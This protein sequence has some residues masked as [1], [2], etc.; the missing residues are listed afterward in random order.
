MA[1]NDTELLL[2]DDDRAVLRAYRNMLARQ[3]FAVQTASNGQA[4]AALLD[5]R[6]FDVIVS[7]IA[8]PEISGID[9][10]RAVRARDLDVPVILMTGGPDLGTAMAAVEHGAFRY[11][12]KP[13]EADEL[14]ATI[15]EAAKLHKMAKLK[16]E[17]QSLVAHS[18]RALDE[19]AALEAR[20]RSA[21][22][23]LWMAFQPIV[24]WREHRVYGYE[25]LLRSS[26]PEMGNPASILDAAE[27][28]GRLHELG[29]AV[30][31]TVAAAAVNAPSGVKLFVNL[32]SADLSDDELYAEDSPLARIADS[33]VLEITER[34]SLGDVRN[35][36]TCIATLKSRGFQMAVDDLGAGY[37]GLTSFT[38]IHPE[39]TKLDM[40]LVRGIDC[41][42]KRKSIVRSMTALCHELGMT[43]VA[44]GVE[45]IA[46]R[47]V[48]K[49][50]E[51]D[52]FQGYFFGRPARAFA[53]L[54]HVA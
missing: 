13:V 38:Q 45:T 46:E 37:S 29:R 1:T 47:D 32:H 21:L 28:L 52:L 44:E 14:R 11:L 19:R 16:R 30:R 43:V 6:S 48:L 26:D 40:S 8:M 41:D 22:D 7:D 36:A 53:A 5:T 23:G 9:F 20:L 27:Q 34:E 39:V 51:C 50:L 18:A 33:V 15:S 49:D 54:E 42:P 25:A 35:L 2:V 17:A 24:D 3:G 4:A 10:L 12:P 31:R